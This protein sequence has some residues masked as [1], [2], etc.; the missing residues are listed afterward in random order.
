MTHLNSLKT[1]IC[2]LKQYDAMKTS[3]M[4]FLKQL[5]ELRVGFSFSSPVDPQKDKAFD[6]YQK[7]KNPMDLLTMRYKLDQGMYLKP[8]DI[9]NDINLIIENALVYNPVFTLITF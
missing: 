8:L 2:N 3:Y 7:I 9:K 6:Y 1:R 4:P 5:Q